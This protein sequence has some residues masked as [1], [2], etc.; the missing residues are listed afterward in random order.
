MAKA[1]GDGGK[2]PACLWPPIS[3]SESCFARPIASN[4]INSREGR[5]GLDDE[6]YDVNAKSATPS[7]SDE[8]RVMLRKLLADRFHLKFHID[9]MQTEV[10]ALVVA[11]SGPKFQL[12]TEAHAATSETNAPGVFGMGPMF[13]KVSFGT[14]ANMLS[15]VCGTFELP[16]GPVIDMTGLKGEYDLRV[17]TRPNPDSGP[18]TLIDQFCEAAPQLGLEFKREKVPIDMYVIDLADRVPTEN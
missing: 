7:S 11:K 16:F 14:L 18:R 6:T 17:K 10:M 3:L 12:A 13:Q 9:T 4:G 8:L 1:L 2:I 5:P 15:G